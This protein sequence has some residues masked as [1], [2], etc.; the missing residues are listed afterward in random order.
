[1]SV[2]VYKSRGVKTHQMYISAIYWICMKQKRLFHNNTHVRVNSNDILTRQNICQS[3]CGPRY[4]SGKAISENL[5]DIIREL[6][7]II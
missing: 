6:Y 7:M 5:F 2:I 3:F 4:V 1:M